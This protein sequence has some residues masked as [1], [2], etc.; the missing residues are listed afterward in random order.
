MTRLDP[1]HSS[2]NSALFLPECAAIP[3]PNFGQN[4]LYISDSYFYSDFWY[5]T[6]FT[7]PAHR[8][9]SEHWLNFDR[10]NWKAEIF[11]NGE[12]LSAASKAASCAAAS[13]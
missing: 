10:I 9:G 11:L 1:C 7:S 5:R 13:T 6:E 4:Q 2:R 8:R 3:D 12:K